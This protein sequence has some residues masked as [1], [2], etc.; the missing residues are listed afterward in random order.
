M[1]PKQVALQSPEKKGTLIDGS[2]LR[3]AQ[4]L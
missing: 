2:T 1:Q 4:L 3:P